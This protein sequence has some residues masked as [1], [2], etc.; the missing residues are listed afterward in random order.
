[1]HGR[2]NSRT[3]VRTVF[4]DEEAFDWFLEEPSTYYEKFR[5]RDP[6]WW[7]LVNLAEDETEESG[8]STAEEMAQRASDFAREIGQVF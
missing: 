7:A 3:W 5:I 1:M 4:K 8:F 2:L 6:W